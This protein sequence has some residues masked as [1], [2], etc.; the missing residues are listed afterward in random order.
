MDISSDAAKLQDAFQ[1]FNE[2]S[3]ALAQSYQELQGQVVRLTEELAAARSERL[4]TLVEKERLAN[5]LQSLLEA[6][7]GGVVV[8]DGEGRVAECNPGAVALL[9][10]ELLQRPWREAL[11]EVL[12]SGAADNPHQ[13]RLRNGRHVSFSASSLGEQPGQIILL[14]DVSEMHALQALVEQQQ[15][16]TAMGEMLAGMAH[17]IRTPLA[18]AL[19]Y[20]GHL[21]GELPAAQRERFSEKLLERLRH[22]Q[23]QVNDMLVFAR[24]GHYAMEKIP[25]R[26]LLEKALQAVESLLKNRR[27]R[28]A[29]E[30]GG[31][32]PEVYLNE[33][34]FLGVLTNLIN[35]AVEALGEDEDGQVTL[36]LSRPDPATLRISVADNGPGMSDEV[37]QR[38]FQPF[39]TTR[40]SGTGLG[41]AV[42]ECVVR[43][44]GGQVQCHTAPDQGATFHIDLPLASEPSFLPAGGGTDSRSL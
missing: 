24:A 29:I 36:R 4:Q 44:H 2:M 31:D 38:V 8:L 22:L 30:D 39:F 3:Q 9:G 41:L 1:L 43:A 20:A 32:N 6:L 25:A 14:T 13:R 34:A 10:I 21:G 37:R 5:R 12:A 23:R 27:V 11:G 16:L 28:L 35:N 40:S 17:Q 15:R 19:L 33:D 7:P 18:A 26:R 42:V